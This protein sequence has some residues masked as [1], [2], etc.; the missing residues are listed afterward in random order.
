MSELNVNND[1]PFSE[2]L[3]IWSPTRTYVL[4]TGSGGRDAFYEAL[5]E[6]LK[7]EEEENPLD[8]YNL[9]KND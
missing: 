9:L 6:A 3:S 5:E 7:R 4:Y 8:K 2:G 1:I